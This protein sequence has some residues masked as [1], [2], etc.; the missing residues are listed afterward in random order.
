MNYNSIQ[1]MNFYHKL[2]K[3]VI[4]KLISKVSDLMILYFFIDIDQNN[5]EIVK[6]TIDKMSNRK[7]FD[8]IDNY[9]YK[10]YCD[11][12]MLESLIDN[13]C[14]LTYYFDHSYCRGNCLQPYYLSK[15]NDDNIQYFGI[16]H[17]QY[18][19]SNK[20]F[21][22]K[23]FKYLD[24][25]IHDKYTQ[26]IE[27]NLAI[28]IGNNCFMNFLEK[29]NSCDVII[30]YLNNFNFRT[31]IFKHT[32]NNN[33]EITLDKNKNI[34]ISDIITNVNTLIKCIKHTRYKV[35]KFCKIFSANEI[36]YI[37]I[38]FESNID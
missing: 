19:F 32:L 15:I 2:N 6:Q 33:V 3:N 10:Y 8:I 20:I 18:I 5:L 7:F 4:N 16:Y 37:Y 21:N 14:I 23:K 17:F 36:L 9:M 24:K 26:I 38:S 35:Y 27:N 1:N 31:I 13:I 25:S 12:K 29:Y 34:T 22:D 28:A 30:D 11:F